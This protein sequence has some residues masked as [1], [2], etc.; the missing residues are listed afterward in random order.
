MGFDPWPSDA[1]LVRAV[2]KIRRHPLRLGN[3]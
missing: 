2:S 1:Q 3:Q